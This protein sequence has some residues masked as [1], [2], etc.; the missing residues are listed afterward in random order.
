MEMLTAENCKIEDGN[1]VIIGGIIS[2][3]SKKI[4]KNNAMMAFIKVEDM[5]G[6]I[7][8]VVFPKVLRKML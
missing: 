2:E 8:V 3:V 4:T 7:E 6:S 1:R 5:Y